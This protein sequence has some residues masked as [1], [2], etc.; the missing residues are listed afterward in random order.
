MGTECKEVSVFHR[1]FAAMGTRLD[2]IFWGLEDGF[3]QSVF[4]EIFEKVLRLDALLSRYNQDSII[5]R[6]NQNAGNQPVDIEPEVF[7]LLCECKHYYTLTQGLFDI[8]VSHGKLAASADMGHTQGNRLKAEDEMNESGGLMMLDKVQLDEESCS[9]FLTGA[10]VKIDLGGIAKGWALDSVRDILNE[11]E[12]KNAFISFGESSILGIGSHPYGR[13]WKTSVNHLFE[14][15]R[16][17][18]SFLLQDTALSTS[19]HTPF[20]TNH[21]IHPRKGIKQDAYSTLS[22]MSESATAAEALSTALLIADREEKAFIFTSFS[23]TPVVEVCYDQRKAIIN[24]L[25]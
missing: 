1:T 15:G 10:N 7:E 23:E 19:G 17:L 8:T 25:N 22:V 14:E 18:Y 21:I 5:C 4:R 24:N 3:A 2:L 9:V 13:G 20:H 6:I 11:K 12:I 16:A